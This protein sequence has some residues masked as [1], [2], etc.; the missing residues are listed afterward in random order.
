MKINKFVAILVLMILL[1]S[2]GYELVK[3]EEIEPTKTKESNQPN[4][5]ETLTQA[6]PRCEIESVIKNNWHNAICEEFNT[7]NPGIWQGN[8]D[9]IQA[10]V[11]NGSYIID[12]K[13]KVTSGYTGGYIYGVAIYEDTNYLISLDG[14]MDSYYKDCFW[15]V[16][17]GAEKNDY[18]YFF[19]IDNLGTW[20]LTYDTDNDA[21]RYLGNMGSGQSGAI[22][23]DGTNNIT[24]VIENG[25]ASF[26]INGDLITTYDTE[27]LNRTETG[28]MVWGGEGVEAKNIFDNLLVKAK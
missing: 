10:Y 19:M 11:S 5:K 16:Y 24:G 13:T 27:K 1:S 26:Y 3:V 12:N 18:G 22:I 2:C 23:W 15:G 17:V 7:S 6:T 9:G 4:I 14:R 8:D 21:M 25:I 28:I 20:S